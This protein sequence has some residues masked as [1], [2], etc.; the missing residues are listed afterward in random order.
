M[1]RLCAVLPLCAAA[2][3]MGR[4]WALM[5]AE[6]AEE[7][8]IGEFAPRQGGLQPELIRE[9]PRFEEAAYD[10]LR[11]SASLADVWQPGV[12]WEPGPPGP[13]GPPGP[14]GPLGL[15]G[16]PGRSG[17][18]G[19]AGRPGDRGDVGP[20]GQLGEPGKE[21]HWHEPEAVLQRGI[22]PVEFF[23]AFVI[24]SI[25]TAA[26]AVLGVILVRRRKEEGREPQWS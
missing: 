1:A 14:K 20:E 18:I 19:V 24:C 17:A 9:M 25:G 2:A 26:V 4:P 8:S 22:Q 23:T 16:P 5:R 7:R 13:Q 3:S 15:Q 11:P 6:S 10:E 12:V 21:A